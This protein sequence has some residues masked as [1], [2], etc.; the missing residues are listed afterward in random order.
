ME[1]AI[2]NFNC[3]GKHFSEIV[4]DLPQQ[5]DMDGIWADK[6]GHYILDEIT[7]CYMDEDS[8]LQDISKRKKVAKNHFNSREE[9]ENILFR[10]EEIVRQYGK[11]SV[12]DMFDMIGLSCNRIA[13]R[14]GWKNIRNVRIE[15]TD[16]GWRI[17]LPTPVRL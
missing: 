12:S 8:D 7:A 15:R 6:I 17:N 1:I 2:R 14:Y 5:S 9:A 10:M 16:G 3:K 4:V 13:N 11:I